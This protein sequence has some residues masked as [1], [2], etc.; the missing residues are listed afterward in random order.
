[1]CFIHALIMWISTETI[2]SKQKVIHMIHCFS[3]RPTYAYASEC[4]IKW[5]VICW[6]TCAFHRFLPLQVRCTVTGLLWLKRWGEIYAVCYYHFMKSNVGLVIWNSIL[7]IRC[8]IKVHSL[9]LLLAGGPSF[10][11]LC[12]SYW[13]LCVMLY[14]CT[15]IGIWTRLSSTIPRKQIR[16]Q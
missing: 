8:S 3:L 5:W 4:E 10:V 16:Q 1:M 7:T 15:P 14:M 2:P 11:Q 13:Q 6:F 12:G 9:C